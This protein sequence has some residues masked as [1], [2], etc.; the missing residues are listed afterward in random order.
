LFFFWF[1]KLT[2]N[3]R[4]IHIHFN[5]VWNC[6]SCHGRRHSTRKWAKKQHENSNKILLFLNRTQQSTRSTFS[7]CK[8]VRIVFRKVRK[9][10][11]TI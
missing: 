9:L 5:A 3:H 10:R 2:Q 6:L 1:L 11:K 8:C 4:A 7:V